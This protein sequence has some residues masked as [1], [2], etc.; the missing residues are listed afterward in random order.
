MTSARNQ[1]LLERPY[2]S[3]PVCAVK[4]RHPIWV[5][6]L[7][8]LALL[9]LLLA[10][11]APLAAQ[12]GAPPSG[13]SCIVSA[14]NRN[15]PLAADGSYTIFGIPG[16][17][18]AIRAR[19]T[20]SDGSVGQSSVGFTNPFQPDTIPL[21]PIVFGSIDPVPV[22]VTLNAENRYLT[23]GQTAQLSATAVALDGSTYD[24]TPRSQG[25]VYS[26]SNDL[27]AT[28]SENGL[29]QIYPQFAPGSSSRVVVSSI[30]EGGVAS[31]YMFVLGPRGILT[32][33]VFASDGVTPIQGAEVSV[34]RIQPM[35]QAGTALTDAQ[36][37]FRL[38]GVNAG[39]FVVSAISPATGDR[40]IGYAQIATEG[41][42]ADLALR[43]NGLG[44]VE[45]TVLDAQ[46]LPVPNTE[47]TFTALGAYRDVRALST[48]ANGMVGFA[49]V[50]AGDFTVSARQPATRLIGTTVSAVAP[51]QLQS[52]ILK[53]QPIG[54]IRG[55]VLDVDGVTPRA[56]VQV[57]IISRQRG[58]LT[59]MLS[60]SDGSF[61][62]DTLPIADSPYTLDAFV[63]GRL[64][65][66]LPGNVL[67]QP[68][69]ILNRDI[70]LAPSGVVRGEVRRGAGLVADAALRLQSLEGLRLSFET[71]AG[72]DGRFRFPAVPVGDYELTATAPNGQ[73]ARVLGRVDSDSQEVVQD[74]VI[75]D[76]TLAGTVFLRDGVTPVGAGIKVYLAR[77]ALGARYTYENA[78]VS[79]GV[80]VTE[81][82]AQGRFGFL[83]QQTSAYYVQA[84][85][86]LERGRSE[87][88]VINL[89]PAQP[90]ETRV[91]FLAK[92]TV[93]GVVRNVA[94]TVQSNAL[95]NV[96]S[97]GAFTLD[98]STHTAPDGSYQIDG[99][100]VGDL[101]AFARNEVTQLSGVSQGRLNAEGDVAVLDVTLAATASVHGL[102]LNRQGQAV[103]GGVRVTLRR[104]GQPLKTEDFPNA[105]Y[106]FTLVP[107]GLIEIEAESISTGDRGLATTRIAGAGDDR[108][109]NVTLIGQGNLAIH[110]VDELGNPVVGA[111]V[112]AA[113]ARPFPLRREGISDAQGN[114]L[115]E[116]L[117]A[118]DYTVS[119]SKILTLG[120]LSGSANG[121]L[122]ANATDSVTIT[123]QN[124]VLGAI[125]G[126]LLMPDGVTPAGAGMVIRMLPEPFLDAFVTTTDADGRYH[127]DQVPAGSYTI[128]ALR[129]YTPT[130]CP[131]QDRV[132]ARANNV[133]VSTQDEVVTAN[134]ILIG[135]GQVRGQIT[136][137]NATPIA[138]AQ[139]TLTNPD[140]VYGSNVTCNGNRTF[141]VS[142]NSNGDYQFDDAPPGNFTL[143]VSVANGNLM[144]EGFGRVRFDGDIVTVDLQLVDSAITM[145]KTL[146][147]ANGF[148]FDVQGYGGIGTGT[149][150]VFAGSGPD[151][152]GMRLELV[153]NGVAVPFVNGDGTIGRLGRNGQQI[154]V[155]DLTASG[156]M[157][158]RETYVPRSGYFARYIEVLRNQSN[159]PIT[160]DVLVK[161][162]HRAAQ[163]NPRVVD[164]SDGDQILNVSAGQARDRWVV[165]DDQVDS[166]PFVNTGSIPATIHLF[167]GDGAATQ[168]AQASYELIGQTGRLTYRWN[169]ITVPAGGE[170]RL[171]HFALNQL[172]RFSARAAAMRLASLP[173]E[174]LEYL[175]SEE[176]LSVLNFV[177][178]ETSVVAPL[179]NLDAGSVSG[180]VF[181]GDG[182]TPIAGAE[183]RFQSKHPL[184]GRI[185]FKTS[186]AQGQFEYRST[187]DGTA[188]N[189]VIPV[190]GFD[191]SARYPITLA[192][193]AV[194]PG[195][196]A[197]EQTAT[198]QDL[199][200]VGHGDVLGTV[201]RHNQSALAA[202][203][204]KLCRLNDRFACTDT[205]PNPSNQTLSAADGGYLL[206]ANP[207]R[208]Y[209]LFGQKS[210]PQNPRHVTARP[211]YGQGQVTVTAGDR[212]VADI[213]MEE[214]GSIAGIVRGADGTPI[215]DAYVEILPT[216]SAQP[217]RG[218]RTDTSGHYRFF[219]V[220]L[221][222]FV[223]KAEDESSNAYG[224]ASA[225]VTVDLETTADIMLRPFGLARVLVNHARGI[226]ANGATVY[227][228]SITVAATDSNGRVNIQAPE[229]AHQIVAK[230][231]EGGHSDLDGHATATISTPGEQID[232][233]V[234]LGSAGAVFGTIV[235]PD[236]STLAGG[237]PYQIRRLSGGS[238]AN[239]SGSTSAAGGFRQSG[240]PLGQYLLTA[241]DAGQDRYIDAEFE[242]SADGQEVELNLV[243]LENRIALPADLRDANRFRFDV[244]Y[245]GGIA[246]GSGNFNGGAAR[247]SVNGSAYTGETSA[248]LEADRRQFLI[249]QPALMDGLKVSRRIYVPRGAYFA[250]YLEIIENPGVDTRTVAVSLKHRL[251]SG[252]VLATSSGDTTIGTDDRWIG[253]DDGTDEDILLD[254]FQIAPTGFLFKSADGTQTPD[255]VSEAMVSG[256]REI[257][258]NWNT[259]TVPAGG[260]VVLMHFIVQQINRA[261]L[262][263]ALERLQQLPPEALNDLGTEDRLGIANFV[264]PP[265]GT[266]TVPPLP[267]LTAS[268]NGR[269]YEG[270]ARTPVRNVR[271][272]VQS[273]HPLFNRIWGKAR[274]PSPDCPPGTIVPSLNSVA[275]VPPNQQNPPA[276]GSYSLA[277]QLTANDSIALPAGV[278]VRL[279][280]Q[281]ATACFSVY[282][283]HSWTNVPS[284][285]ENPTPSATQDLIF[286]TGVLTGTAIGA[287]D[288]SVTSGRMYLSIDDPDP[289]V[290]RYIPIAADGTWT[291]PG[292]LAGS[293][294]VLFDTRHPNGTG[295]DILRGHVAAAAVNVG[296][297]L[298]QDVNLQPTGRV[299]GAIVSATG[300]Q[301]VAA[302]VILNGAAADQVYDRCA[303]GCDPAT[304][305][306]H[307][308][309]RLVSREVLTDSL[310]RYQ[311]SAV[312]PGQYTLTVIDPISDGRSTRSLSVSA[313]QTAVQNVTLLPLGRA[314]LVVLS[315]NGQPVVDA[316]VYLQSDAQG[317]EKVVGRTDFLGRLTV[318]NI[319]ASNYRLRVTDPRN[320]NLRYLD[321]TVN[322]T[323]SL[324]GQ[325]DPQT[326]SMLAVANLNITVINGAVGS[327]GIPGALVRLTDA[328]G[329]LS[330]NSTNA[331]GQT[332]AT[333]VPEGTPLIHAAA[334]IAGVTREG[335]LPVTI[336]AAEDNQTL[337]VVVNL[338]E[339][340]I[341]LPNSFRDANRAYYYVQPDGAGTYQPA[342][343]ISG[344]AFVG[345]TNA[346]RQLQQRQFVISQANPIAGLKVTRKIFVPLNGYFARYLE[347]L[348][349][350]GS[351]PVS[352]DVEVTTPRQYDRWIYETSSGDDQ[353]NN[354]TWL[355]WT[356]GFSNDYPTDGALYADAPERAPLLD[357]VEDNGATSLR[358][359][360]NNVVVPAGGRRIVMHFLAMQYGQS[361]ARESVLRL[362][363]L[364]PEALDGLLSETPGAIL[365]FAVPS[366]ASSG[367][368]ALPSL[369]GRVRGVLREGDG[370][371]IANTNVTIQSQHPLF[372][373]KWSY[374]TV[375]GLRTDGDGHFAM[376]GYLDGD[377]G[378][379][380]LPIDAPVT[381]TAQHPQA[382][383]LS[384]TATGNFVADLA[385]QDL[386]FE[387]AVVHGV[388]T[389]AFQV[390]SYTGSVVIQGAASGSMSSDGSYRI[391]GV[392]AGT[393][394]IRATLVH[395]DGDDL[396]AFVNGV[397]VAAGTSQRLDIALPPNGAVRGVIRSATGVPLASATVRLQ[398]PGMNRVVVTDS[399]GEYQFNG[400]LA[401]TGTIAVV[402]PRSQ[403]ITTQP[404]TI[405]ANQETVLDFA[406]P[407]VG[408]VNVALAYARGA[409]A[410]NVAVYLSAPSIQ[411]RVLIG[412]TNAQGQVSAT[413]P[414]GNLTVEADHPQTFER[415]SASGALQQDGETLAL[416]LTLPPA[417][418][419][420]ANVVRAGLAVPGAT[421]LIRRANGV[422]NVLSNGNTN[423]V[424]QFQSGWLRADELLLLAAG[425]PDAAQARTRIDASNDGTTIA[426]PMTLSTEGSSSGVL[427]FD[428]ERHLHAVTLT[429]GERLSL[430]AIGTA[431][432]AEPAICGVR[433]VVYGPN[434]N[435]IAEG[436]GL[437]PNNYTQAN[438]I[439]DLRNIVASTSGQYLIRVIREY[440]YCPL[441]GYQLLGYGDAAPISIDRSVGTARV[442]GRVLRADGVT[443]I[444]DAIVRLRTFS[445]P[446]RYEQVRADAAGQF[447]F[448]HLEVGGFELAYWTDA[449]SGPVVVANAYVNN[450]GDV[451][452]QNLTVSPTTTVNVTVLEGGN[453]LP[454]AQVLFTSSSVYVVRN[455]NQQGQVSYSYRGSSDLTVLAMHPNYS[456]VKASTIVTA[457]DGQVRD[458]TLDLAH[459][460]VAGTVRD[461]GGTA[462]ANVQI[463]AFL[464]NEYLAFAQSD[465]F[466]AY[467]F[468]QLVAGASIQI[469]A[470]DPVNY[471]QSVEQVTLVSGTT[472]QRDLILP[473]HANIQLQV[474]DQD[475]HPVPNATNFTE[476]EIL[477]G[478][479]NVTTYAYGSTDSSGARLIEG[480]PVGRPIRVVAEYYSGGGAVAGETPKGE[481]GGG[482]VQAETTVTLDTAGQVLPVELVLT[483]PEVT[484]LIADI[485]AADSQPIDQYCELY[486]E[487]GNGNNA[488]GYCDDGLVL[489]DAPSGEQT[490][491]L[492]MGGNEI[493]SGP[494]TLTEGEDNAFSYVTSV[495]RGQVTHPEGAPVT[496]A[497]VEVE[498]SLGDTVYTGTNGDG[499]YRF[500]NVLPGAL[501]VRAGDNDSTL[502][503][504]ASST[505][506]TASSLV[507][508][509]LVMPPSGLVQGIVRDA[510]GN[511]VP[512]A[513]IVIR[514]VLTDSYR[515]VYAN[516]S[517]AYEMA[518]VAVGTF[519]ISAI[520]PGT[521]LYAV[522]VG[523]LTQHGESVTID[524]QLP[525]PG[526][527]SGEVRD[528]QSAPMSSQC[529]E[530]RPVRIGAGHSDA[531]AQTQTDALGAYSFAEVT[532]GDY[533]LSAFTC[534]QPDQGAMTLASVASTQNATVALTWGTAQSL[535]RDF[536]DA[537][538]GLT[539]SLYNDGSIGARQPLEWL[540]FPFYASPTLIVTQPAI[541]PV[542]YPW[543]VLAYPFDSGQTYE[544]PPARAGDLLIV[545][546]LHVPSAGGYVRILETVTN[547][548]ATSISPELHIEGEHGSGAVLLPAPPAL[549]SAFAVQ[550]TNAP[551]DYNAPA[552][553]GYVYAGPSALVPAAAD[554]APGRMAF[555]YGW[556]P[557]VA[558]GQSVS[559]LHYVLFGQPGDSSAVG[560]R[561]E[562]LSTLTETNMFDGLSPAERSR[563]VNFQ[564]P[565][566]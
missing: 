75:A 56:G 257:S 106:E 208:H 19:A 281:E 422:N 303:T 182:V 44:T 322:G 318:A 55:R 24:V 267:S 142:T 426:V 140:T 238:S 170:V 552:V 202:A 117:F 398:L 183:V 351:N 339:A 15:A 531:I 484:R 528:D 279:T 309:K 193:T 97:E 541:G 243:L 482:Y 466:G 205:P 282:S 230:H 534:G 395:Q 110:L 21:G 211:I 130:L 427:A 332:S 231:P 313:N 294:D 155:D 431:I 204:V 352:V 222:D 89:N 344:T 111:R 388:V 65:A 163:S 376:D 20:C 411:G 357:Q 379:L 419:V 30:S 52:I 261:G 418:R 119:A 353:V 233:V 308:G 401:T 342:L 378:G 305:T 539:V 494:I 311:F 219:D 486:L 415:A 37:R 258:V 38:E 26:I 560:A 39:N 167:D 463:E 465:E 87:A 172:N 490:L 9:G 280:A 287:P 151:N 462:V 472:V 84:E 50:A 245:S 377:T 358:A 34:L 95:V 143:D 80:L 88:T 77:K 49:N 265:P 495:L 209:F 154:D 409:P 263:A 370:S 348:E 371:A 428:G 375:L 320:G 439:G 546:K 416:P 229:G 367:V 28:V 127:F 228:G 173:P 69:E 215:V 244:Q 448:D 54:D 563:I 104:D 458:V 362:Q 254:H 532:P 126:Q 145:P 285:V 454:Y 445:T 467:S 51:G 350:E 118:G 391:G 32:G 488:Y 412:Y 186:N 487:S 90:L 240:L 296:Q 128:D 548:G 314:E 62:F 522:A 150:T 6:A 213:V 456:A 74:V 333:F 175:S 404:L 169:Q 547:L 99:V 264:M 316:F 270:D 479:G 185:R 47:V 42:V 13:A 384:A 109:L 239:R 218:T 134:L 192:Q 335:E 147:D 365:N 437:G 116:R 508:L 200:M 125:E 397:V 331:Q 40:A 262:D 558:P 72:P 86:D 538:S 390:P 33:T 506:P 225:T 396:V 11:S 114:V 429:A 450:P 67:A 368:P 246:V 23:T 234:T 249:A 369:L 544:L 299:E 36:G 96:R 399:D 424:G 363:Q 440:S 564:V 184:F 408:T 489:T 413:A 135:Q 321:R 381:L 198:Q 286:D 315:R 132:R 477:I 271:V 446:D 149:N 214:T 100:F 131:R 317:F 423:S 514:E 502:R 221:G 346:A 187:L 241:Y 181:S 326:V 224:T 359:R 492:L 115:L 291:Y 259:L 266:E 464:G 43:L 122:L 476:F 491:H 1:Q 553:A 196:F 123:M 156:L 108:L 511:P 4:P 497:W 374:S 516:Q 92:G 289:L 2:V 537:V 177:L 191:L 242:L 543:R 493:Y 139:V 562:A 293:Y 312:P 501:T 174:M 410:A 278:P 252:T 189:Y 201:K 382:V 302:R 35:E 137:A 324:Q 338:A 515:S 434:R 290:S 441:G 519:E 256:R 385:E 517:G 133:T 176:K 57:R 295:N 341:P 345:A 565:T 394:S 449:A 433:V 459:G 498:N 443:P 98:R 327:V 3:L 405:N 451:V 8:L 469:R 325:V 158:R 387:S 556:T 550:A 513:Q 61:A 157:V 64:R 107:A 164:T 356:Q 180:S 129:F 330:L 66:R 527:V 545:R 414:V 53:L 112:S 337:S 7:R 323:I 343:R 268:V 355:T 105:N 444:A 85:Q 5:G 328:R 260:R 121:T 483:L 236:N 496:N 220:P 561:A 269:V 307:K 473:A 288:L 83:V 199:I 276:L 354:D 425:A 334:E 41:E 16:N 253:I 347:I 12:V 432:G 102:V 300:E 188:Q 361:A 530:I 402:D 559:L 310:G 533:I 146:Y 58:I 452:I 18:G 510:G 210:H 373:R 447:A 165:I 71:R 521:A 103:T 212:E 306:K 82:D 232:V 206:V 79:D 141:V 190:F 235:R 507:T 349:N 386:V 442:E 277:G 197:A 60:R 120:T 336:G 25:T 76:D 168:V 148:A 403:A 535:P 420:Q 31:T 407:S 542:W 171:M 248:R 203:S 59:Q 138:G 540:N 29:V 216:A 17:L 14:G 380:P 113:N 247:L 136:L 124:L 207:P 438:Y 340:L 536:A 461:S 383:N 298:V 551:S 436:V 468:P 393:W 283:G 500:L 512:D 46:D 63:D 284:R 504:E 505:M 159:D 22:A 417:A 250:R 478:S 526:S 509:D 78:P 144:A 94:G 554:F 10:L 93:R 460:G 161:S 162:H 275:T 319:A 237:F 389:G 364:P 195:D 392:R 292:L 430:A 372:V 480:L 194:A 525:V 549:P 91:V 453:P 101:S 485:T 272:T 304:L 273:T 566:P 529:V 470:R 179:P 555:R 152:G 400:A 360:W 523:A 27:L 329:N 503:I 166:D 475:G 255:Q 457:A 524:L 557:T 301:S 421:V 435:R 81:T 178:P 226:P 251:A 518:R 471:S 70:V 160:V 45:V 297:I 499:H 73:T 520:K 406:L 366:D 274:D 455:A 227:F 153:K 48:G 481:G 223:V 474:V 217:W 68:N